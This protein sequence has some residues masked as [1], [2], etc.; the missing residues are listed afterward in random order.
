MTSEV[1]TCFGN[2]FV[3]NKRH[4]AVWTNCSP[5]HLSICV[6]PGLNSLTLSCVDWI[7]PCYNSSYKCCKVLT[8]ISCSDYRR[9]AGSP[10]FRTVYIFLSSIKC[11]WYF[12]AFLN[13]DL[14]RDI[15]KNKRYF[16][17]VDSRVLLAGHVCKCI[18]AIEF[19]EW[20]QIVPTTFIR[21]FQ[22][23]C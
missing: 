3:A 19:M 15:S 1:R 8:F 23:N 12:V 14:P 22:R 16:S 17:L 18:Y 2:R 10:V 20:Y 11:T 6:P 9:T 5:A 4:A 21:M 13:N 7:W